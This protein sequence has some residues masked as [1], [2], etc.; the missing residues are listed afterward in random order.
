MKQRTS[1][2]SN[3]PS[4]LPS[5]KESRI[6]AALELT[7]IGTWEFNLLTEEVFFNESW[8]NMLGYTLKELAPLSV[9]AWHQHVHP[10][11]LKRSDAAIAR[12]L[13]GETDSYQCTV[14]MKHRKGHWLWI[15]ARA[16]VVSRT[17]EGRP[18]WLYGTHRD[19]SDQENMKSRIEQS[20]NNFRAFFNGS[21]DYLWVLDEQGNIID[22]NSTSLT[23]LDYSREELIGKSVLQVHPEP[24]REEALHTVQEMLSGTKDKCSIP[25]V[26]K[27]GRTIPV[28][29]RVSMAVWN[30]NPAVFGVSRDITALVLSEEKYTK[31][32]ETSPAMIGLIEMETLGWVDVN[33]SFSKHTGYSWKEVNQNRAADILG[34]SRETESWIINI[35]QDKGFLR[36][37]EITIQTKY[38]TSLE[39]LASFELIEL[40]DTHLIYITAILINEQKEAERQLLQTLS[41]EKLLREELNHRVKNNLMMVGSLISLKN[42]ELGET[43]DLADLLSRVQAITSLHQQ[44]QDSANISSIPL[45]PY[46]RQVI[47]TAVH[48]F[49]RKIGINFNVTDLNIDTRRAVTLG[50]IINE[51]AT[52]AVKHG[53]TDNDDPKI[54][55]DIRQQDTNYLVTFSN[56]G[57]PIAEDV[58]FEK[59]TTLGLRLI[60]TLVQ[61]IGGDLRIER[62]PHP[63]FSLSIPVETD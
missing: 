30:G 63:V 32:F 29:T 24:R 38:G 31:L 43:A 57:D 1:S 42:A 62:S 52:N 10:E 50:L 16:A 6:Q 35:L 47:F 45:G 60:S 39:V 2:V 8:A 55:I 15:D 20:E 53:F 22:T 18:E 59:G 44:L 19:V 33:P 17:P 40:R 54:K 34:V 3:T 4:N 25:L 58:D 56:N 21:L 46:I 7:G 12:Y 26:S 36:N 48:N 27:S 28:E 49:N 37:K 11:D 23:N 14:R 41:E 13:A 9:V 61:Q 5:D 51:L